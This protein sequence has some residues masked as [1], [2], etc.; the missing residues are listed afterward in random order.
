MMHGEGGIE[1]PPAGSNGRRLNREEP[2]MTHRRGSQ[3]LVFALAALVAPWGAPAQVNVGSGM[4][5]ARKT[6]EKASKPEKE[7]AEAKSALTGFGLAPDAKAR[8]EV[9][10]DSKRNQIGFT[11]RA[12]KETI[13]GKT[14]KI[15]G[16]L[17]LN[18][19]KLNALEGQLAVAWKD[20]DT[21]KSGMNNHMTHKPWVDADSHP[22]IVF[23]VTG[24]EDVRV[25]NE[26]S[27]SGKVIL[28]G[29]LAMNGKEKEMRIPATLLWVGKVG[30][31]PPGKIRE[32]IGIK[33]DF[34]VALADFG[35]EG[36]DGV[37][38]DKVAKEQ[39]IKVSVQLASPERDRSMSEM[40]QGAPKKKKKPL[41]GA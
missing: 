2:P 14:T 25:K 4:Q 22:E 20:I 1:P 9:L 12:P 6:K 35:I 3:Y 31:S 41:K 7:G 27:K 38:G 34:K 28:V 33:A 26:K 39:A 30:K 23:N 17:E 11:S 5:E 18:P 16:H 19:R 40:P 15:K 21:G 13:E 29:K 32:G 10:A 8:Y 37:V 36:K 24:I